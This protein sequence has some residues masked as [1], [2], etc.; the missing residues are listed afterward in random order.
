MNELDAGT[1]VSIDILKR[2]YSALQNSGEGG[3]QDDEAYLDPDDY[4]FFVNAFDM[5][6][7]NWSDERGTFDK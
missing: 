6:L 1:K 3:P 5:P 2:V 7:W 4:L